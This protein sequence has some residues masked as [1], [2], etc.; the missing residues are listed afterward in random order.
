[1]DKYGGSH[2]KKMTNSKVFIH[3]IQKFSINFVC[4]VENQKTAL[5]KENNVL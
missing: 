3:I 1:M 4:F 5:R 2:Y